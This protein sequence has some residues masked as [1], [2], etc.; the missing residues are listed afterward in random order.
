VT[1]TYD[2]KLQKKRQIKHNFPELQV[3][4]GYAKSGQERREESSRGFAGVNST[5]A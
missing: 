2:E 1:F 5:T 3:A 4:A